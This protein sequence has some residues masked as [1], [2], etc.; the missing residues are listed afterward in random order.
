MIRV[1]TAGW[2]YPD[3]EG[4]VYPDTKPRGFHP[5]AFLA[6]F[7]D[8]VEINSSFYAVPNPEHAERWLRCV[9]DLPEFRFLAKLQ[10]VFTHEALPGTEDDLAR[11]AAPWLAGIEP[12]RASGRLAAVLVQFPVTFRYGEGARRRLERLD[13]QFGHLPLALE[14]R[15]RTW[16]EEPA[17]EF[18]ERLGMSLVEIDLP[19]SREHPPLGFR[20]VGPIGYLRVHGRNAEAWFEPGA[21]RDQRYDYLYGEEELDELAGRAQRLASGRDDTY[22]ITNN[23]FGGQAA[24]NALEIMARLGQCPKAPATLAQ[25]YPRLRTQ[26]TIEGQETLF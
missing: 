12:L 5:L 6:R 7:L 8:C 10:N 2:S 14:V 22:V 9:A 13:A 19:A 3:W 24:A 17:L 15:H 25:A 1:G 26:A 18:A 16:F 20:P 21:G 4:P 11:L 23:H